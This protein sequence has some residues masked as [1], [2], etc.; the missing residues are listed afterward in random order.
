MLE[1]SGLR[2]RY[3]NGALGVLDVS[4]S[5]EPG[6][7][8]AVFGPNGAGKTTSVRACTGFLKSEGASVVAG[9]VR[10]DGRDMTGAEPHRFCR[11]GIFCIPERR[12]IFPHL[13]VADNLKAVRYLPARKARAEV[14]ERI[15]TLFPMLNDLLGL[16]AGR[17]SGGQQQMLAIARGL[18][19]EPRYLVIDEISLGLH[20]SVIRPLFEVLRTIAE[21]G[22]AVLVVDETTDAALDVADHCYVL[23]SGRVVD[24]GSPDRFRGSELIAA[25]YVGDT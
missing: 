2:V 20:V 8:V 11:R 23:R 6:K 1:A 21:S 7:V 18:M 14:Q 9:H 4:L 24:E 22:T 13:T 17:L 5:A 25:G 15:F 16:Q 10:L 12:K 19:S 3:R